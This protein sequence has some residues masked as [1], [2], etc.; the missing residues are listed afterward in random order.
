[1][2]R[3]RRCCCVSYDNHQVQKEQGV[4]DTAS[5]RK[6]KAKV[7]R[8][9]RESGVRHRLEEVEEQGVADTAKKQAKVR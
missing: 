2:R 5:L 7:S 8:E 1:M 3:R 4:A 6:K 9:G